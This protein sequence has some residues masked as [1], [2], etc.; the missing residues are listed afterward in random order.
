MRPALVSKALT[1]I[2]L[3]VFV[4]LGAWAQQVLP[5]P[6]LTAR[7]IDTTGTLQLARAMDLPFLAPIPE[8]FIHVAL[9]A[10]FATF[11][12]LVIRLRR[13]ISAVWSDGSAAALGDAR[14]ESSRH[15]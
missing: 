12:G 13:A 1:A 7:V 6:A 10:W 4:A 15:P 9:A 3:V 2:F 8:A 14:D 11:A 5:V